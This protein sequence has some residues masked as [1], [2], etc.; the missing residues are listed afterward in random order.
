[1]SPSPPDSKDTLRQTAFRKRLLLS[2]AARK[3]AAHAMM[4]KFIQ[5]APLKA[6]LVIGGYWPIHSEINVLPLLT[7]LLSLGYAC[8]LPQITGK[9][10]PLVF[11]S[12]H[13]KTPMRSGANEMKEP[14]P[15]GSAVV[16]PD[17]LIVPLLAFDSERHRLGYG[18]GYYDRTFLH[19]KKSH[20]FTVIGV[21]Y[22]TQKINKIPASEQDHKMDMIVTDRNV[23][24]PE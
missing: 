17:L 5:E 3:Q 21:A 13:E 22:D 6:G 9:D 1:M 4:E 2:A 24:K 14:D 19:L 23:Y 12:W 10:K 11:R 18:A 8:A 7:R 16:T 20:A 15:A